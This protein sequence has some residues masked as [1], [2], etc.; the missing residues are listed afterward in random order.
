MKVQELV[1]LMNNPKNKMLK[2]DQKQNLIRKELEV[3]KYITIKDKKEIVED[4]VD[5]CILFEGGMFKFDEI[6]KYLCFTM[7]V[8]A[9]YTNIELSDDIE[10]DYDML[11][12]NDLLE[13]VISTFKTE[14]DNV[15]V[16]L[17]MRCDY[18]LSGNSIEAQLGKFLEDV[19]DRVDVLVDAFANK[20][21]SFD[22]N[23]LPVSADDITKLLEFMN[24]MK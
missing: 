6:D 3:K 21:E 1:N 8:I 13:L 7:K 24:K 22:M 11:C 16:L 19:L 2:P 15:S 18:L 4:I 14:Y 5:E 10:A 12:E 17:Q 20:V 23:N 9:A